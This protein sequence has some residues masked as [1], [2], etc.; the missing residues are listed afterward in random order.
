MHGLHLLAD[1]RECAC[2]DRVLRDSA[3][4]LS[5][6]RAACVRAELTVVGESSHTFSGGGYT[7]ALLLAESHVTIHTWPE[8]VSATMDVFVCNHTRDNS[9]RAREVA[10]EIVAHFAPKR[11]Q[12]SEVVRGDVVDAPLHAKKRTTRSA[13]IAPPVRET[14]PQV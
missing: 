6:A 14:A 10:E 3:A 9:L 8:L 11:A 12:I 4:M 2:D 7:L 5:L 1:L 13:S